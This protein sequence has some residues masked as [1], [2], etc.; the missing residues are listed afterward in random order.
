MATI[1]LHDRIHMCSN[2]GH[3]PREKPHL[4][5]PMCGERRTITIG[6]SSALALG[7][8]LVAECDRK[9]AGRVAA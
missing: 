3:Y 7:V 1:K 5:C 2:C 9:A 6:R 8:G 4:G